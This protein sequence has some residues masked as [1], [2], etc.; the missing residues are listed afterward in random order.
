MSWTC[1]KPHRLRKDNIGLREVTSTDYSSVL[2]RSEIRLYRKLISI[3]SLLVVMADDVGEIKTLNVCLLGLVMVEYRVLSIF[4]S[5]GLKIS[6]IL[7]SSCGRN[8][9]LWKQSRFAS[10]YG[11]GQHLPKGGTLYSTTYV[12]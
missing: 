6:R 3:H 1:E 9:E 7:H 4:V 11:R 10:T 2:P 8:V 12:L 5:R